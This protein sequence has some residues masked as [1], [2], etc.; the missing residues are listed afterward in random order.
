MALIKCSECKKQVSDKAVSCPHCGFPL[1]EEPKKDTKSMIQRFKE[2]GRLKNI[3]IRF[4]LSFLI[5]LLIIS[6]ITY[7]M[8]YNGSNCLIELYR[9]TQSSRFLLYI[10][11]GFIIASNFLLCLIS[12]KLRKA[13]KIIDIIS[14]VFLVVINALIVYGAN[15]RLTL[16]VYPLMY[17]ALLL[18]IFFN[19]LE[20]KKKDKILLV[21]LAILGL[22]TSI[23]FDTYKVEIPL[24]KVDSITSL[25]KG[26]TMVATVSSDY[27][28]VR[29]NPDSY[30]KKIDTV[31]KGETYEVLEIIKKDYYRW[32]LI[33]TKNNIEGY[34][35]NPHGGDVYLTFSLVDDE[36]TSEIVNNNKEENGSKQEEQTTAPTTQTEPTEKTTSYN[37]VNTTRR[38]TTTT[39][40]NNNNNN[41]NSSVTTTKQKTTTTTRTTTNN[42]ALCDKKIAERTAKYNTDVAAVDSKYASLKSNAKRDM[43]NAYSRLNSNGG[44][45]SYSY[46]SSR[47]NSLSSEL[48]TAQTNLQRAM[49]DTS[50]ASNSKRIYYQNRIAEITAEMSRLSMRYD[51]S[52]AYDD[53]KAYYNQVLED[54]EWE[55]KKL[56]NAYSSDLDAIKVSC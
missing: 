16:F 31:K 3:L 2:N 10:I 34:I 55:L 20:D 15:I 8:N 37:N 18:M 44:Y 42:K 27:I 7:G 32:Y 25:S 19:K 52:V 48:S 50:G 51:L 46:Y 36:K 29:I 54:Y 43:D 4:G 9:E 11:F 6:P 26:K 56:Y 35:A 21:I 17:I 22:I 12:G 14:I 38:K 40:K 39:K 1:K 53:S 28:N 47:M 41:S 23:V 45:I 5:F 33:K 30:S 24:N 49:M 13:N